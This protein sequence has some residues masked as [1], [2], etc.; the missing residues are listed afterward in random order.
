VIDRVPKLP[1]AAGS[2]RHAAKPIS[3]SWALYGSR[4]MVHDEITIEVDLEQLDE[5]RA[6][7]QQR[8]V[9]DMDRILAACQP[10]G[11]LMTL[12]TRRIG[13]QRT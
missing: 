2:Y 12:S 4:F 1:A 5:I 11:L 9:A 8:L 3:F 6:E 13:T 10:P 7:I